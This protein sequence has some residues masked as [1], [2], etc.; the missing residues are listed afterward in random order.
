ML[1]T[2]VIIFCLIR[3]PS[4]AP[5]WCRILFPCVVSHTPTGGVK[6]EIIAMISDF[7]RQFIIES[8]L[9]LLVGRKWCL[10]PKDRPCLSPLQLG[11]DYLDTIE[12]SVV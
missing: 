8:C 12:K 6:K 2:S 3:L 11:S 7:L 9:T 4:L 5:H 1:Y 10:W